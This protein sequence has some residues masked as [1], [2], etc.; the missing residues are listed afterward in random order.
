MYTYMCVYIY[1][2]IYIYTRVSRAGRL[3]RGDSP[4]SQALRFGILMNKLWGA[5]FRYSYK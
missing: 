2:Y 4:L 3:S 5:K 1:I